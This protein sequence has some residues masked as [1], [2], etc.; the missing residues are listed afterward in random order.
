M[1]LSWMLG[2]NGLAQR[3]E[4]L[5]RRLAGRV[6]RYV[7]LSIERG[8]ALE[9]TP[10]ILHRLVVPGHRTAASFCLGSR[11]RNWVVRVSS[12]ASP[13]S[14]ASSSIRGKSRADAI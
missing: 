4:T 9:Y 3:R 12:T 8:P 1:G 11:F 6:Q 2:G 5:L 7:G 13:D 14:S 10:Q